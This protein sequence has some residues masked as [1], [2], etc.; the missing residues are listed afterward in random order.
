VIFKA[1][2][3][4]FVIEKQPFPPD[5]VI[6]GMMK[7]KIIVV[8]V[9]ALLVTGLVAC[10]NAPEPPLPK[11]MKGYEL[12]S[13]QDAGQWQ[14]SLLT[15][16]NR[17]KT[18]GEIVTGERGVTTDGWVNLTAVGV[19]A[20]K[21]ILSRIP[22]GEWVSWTTGNFVDET[23]KLSII[24]ELPP[25]TIIDEVKAYAENRGINFQVY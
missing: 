20:V 1:E 21:A 25:Q 5:C 13:W 14:F 17:T 24:L 19:D 8:L 9:L 23:E 16:T 11:S 3:Q 6:L 7:N 15:G 4:P 22:A 10:N 12:Y 18:M 2:K